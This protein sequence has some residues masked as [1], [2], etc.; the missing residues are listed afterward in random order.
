MSLPF[1]CSFHVSAVRLRSTF[2]RRIHILY[3]CVAPLGGCLDFPR[4]WFYCSAKIVR[5]RKRWRREGIG[6]KLR[7]WWH[8]G[9]LGEYS[10]RPREGVFIFFCLSFPWK[11]IIH[12]SGVPL[13]RNPKDRQAEH[14]N[15]NASFE[16]DWVTS[17]KHGLVQ[18]GDLQSFQDQF[19]NI[20]G[21][22]EA[23]TSVTGKV[24]C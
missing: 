3:N 5:Q 18:N 11:N 8:S 12:F 13:I 15:H 4:E 2:R 6:E 22:S 1:Q 17:H 16:L 10:G 19:L 23:E 24:E 9:R 20:A 21:T 14:H 7:E